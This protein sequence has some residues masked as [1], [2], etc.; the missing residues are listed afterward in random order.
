MK[1]RYLDL[2]NQAD[3]I[4]IFVKDTQIIP[5]GTTL[6]SMPVRHKNAEYDRYARDYDI[7][8]LF[9]DHLPQPNFYAV[10][11]LDIFAHDGSGGYL[12]SLETA[13]DFQSDAKIIYVD[14]KRRCFLTAENGRDFLKNVTDWR[15]QC[16]PFAGIILF[17]GIEEAKEHFEFYEFE[18]Q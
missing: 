1:K 14:A 11:R 6:S 5:A 10:P 2:T 7:H 8:F 17:P 4:S 18:N 13:V 16:Q 3:C 12:C 9:E 15:K